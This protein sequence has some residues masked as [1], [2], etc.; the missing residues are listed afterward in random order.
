[1]DRREAMIEAIER[2]ARETGGVTGRHVLAAPVLS[3]LREVRRDA[4]VPEASETV[5][6]QNRA[7]PIGHDQTISQPFV[8][9]LMTDLLD[10][11]ATHRVLE[12]GTGS[13][14]QTAILAALA[15]E[16][17]SVEIVPSLAERAR[18]A[19]ERA[20]CDNV[21]LRLGDGARGWSEQAPFD[22]IIVTAAARQI[23]PALV[24]QLRPGGRLVI[25][26][27]A[28]HGDQEL[29]LVTKDAAGVVSRHDILAVAF[30]PLTGG[31]DFPPAAGTA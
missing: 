10:L 15:G 1:M 14:Y 4:F 18:A 22:A 6:W 26:L 19:L 27:G 30:V 5:A 24:E 29:V 17:F 11:S 13:G 8:V 28:P 31:G 7:L 2:D 16:V 20:G 23:P 25:P 12:I 3:A 9:G 21:F